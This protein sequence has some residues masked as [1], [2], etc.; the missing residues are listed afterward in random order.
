VVVLQWIGQFFVFFLFL[1]IGHILY[2]NIGKRKLAH[3]LIL[4][5]VAAIV[6]LVLL[7]FVQNI[8]LLALWVGFAIGLIRGDHELRISG[9]RISL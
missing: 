9:R 7:H 6:T 5:A 1:R 2:F 8:W 3:Y 4:E